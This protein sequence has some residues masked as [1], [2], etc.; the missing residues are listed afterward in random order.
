MVLVN[1]L[2]L[3]LLHT[4]VAQIIIIQPA[5]LIPP[6]GKHPTSTKD[7]RGDLAVPQ[8]V[9]AENLKSIA[10]GLELIFV[11]LFGVK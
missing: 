3:V 6:I 9:I 10:I 11:R 5:R 4:V 7:H 1:Q 2:Y 8:I